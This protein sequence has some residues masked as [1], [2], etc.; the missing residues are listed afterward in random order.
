MPAALI[1]FLGI[2]TSACQLSVPEGSVD[3]Y[4]VAK[5][6]KDFYN[7]VGIATGIESV[8]RHGYKEAINSIYD[9]N[10][11]QHQGL[12]HGLNI[13]RMSDGTVRKTM[14]K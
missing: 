2:D 13:V 12:R 6:W 11:R 1:S 3:A 8:T 7:I 4:K 9:L 5:G 10:G 14:M